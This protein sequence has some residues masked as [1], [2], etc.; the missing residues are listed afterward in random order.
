MRRQRWQGEKTSG[1]AVLDRRWQGGFFEG[2]R[3]RK[4]QKAREWRQSG[5]NGGLSLGG[6]RC[7][8][9]FSYKRVDNGDS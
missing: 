6:G 7:G 1:E 8:G 9:W 4:S 3:R 2:G 5:T